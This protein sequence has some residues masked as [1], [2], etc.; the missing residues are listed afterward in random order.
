MTLEARTGEIGYDD[1]NRTGAA[2]SLDRIE[3][4]MA[5]TCHVGP[6]RSWAELK[7]FID[8]AET[9]LVAAMYEF[10]AKHIADGFK[11]A[12]ARRG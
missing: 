2:F 6:E 10:N 9:K 4:E 3:G 5:V 11:D 12:M 7:Q 1:D 8:G